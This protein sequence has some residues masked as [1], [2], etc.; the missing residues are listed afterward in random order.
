[1]PAN[2]NQDVDMRLLCECRNFC[3]VLYSRFKGHFLKND[4]L[5]WGRCLTL[6]V[7]AMVSPSDRISIVCVMLKR[8]VFAFFF[9]G[10]VCR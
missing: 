2:A 8:P 5:N 6:N 4:T 9:N 7:G 3:Q 1:M 10:T